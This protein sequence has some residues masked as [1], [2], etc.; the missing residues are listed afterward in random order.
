MLQSRNK[1]MAIPSENELVNPDLIDA[2][3]VCGWFLGKSGDDAYEMYR[4][5]EDALGRDF[6]I[7]GFEAFSYLSVGGL[8][9][10]LPPAIRYVEN[11][12]S[13]GNRDFVCGLLASL[14]THLSHEPIRRAWSPQVA[15]NGIPPD[16]VN[17]I[18]KLA[19]FVRQNLQKFNLEESDVATVM[20]EI[21]IFSKQQ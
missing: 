20:R 14:S 4:S 19:D 10:Y 18:R 12:E 17:S 15:P 2:P 5:G 11:P 3:W 8:E 7:S 9:Y 6:N 16:V 21:E 13:A 1:I